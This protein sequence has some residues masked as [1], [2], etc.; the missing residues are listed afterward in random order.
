MKLTLSAQNLINNAR[1][2]KTEETVVCNLEGRPARQETE[3]ADTRNIWTIARKMHLVETDTEEREHGP[4]FMRRV[5]DRWEQEF[6]ERLIDQTLRDNTARFKKEAEIANLVLVRRHKEEEEGDD[7]E[8]EVVAAEKESQVEVEGPGF[9]GELRKE[10]MKE[11]C[12][13]EETFL[14]ELSHLAATTHQ[15]IE[16]R[17]R[18]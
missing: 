15:D 4:G 7:A 3:S 6:G 14:L 2:F 1:R 12:I 18:L 5:G 10:V 17:R 11:E 8:E 16:E 9:E 13:L